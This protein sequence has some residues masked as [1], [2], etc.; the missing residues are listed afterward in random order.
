M[1]QKNIQYTVNCH[2]AD[3]HIFT[4][5]LQVDMVTG[6][7]LDFKMAAWTPGS[8]LIREY[9]RN[10]IEFSAKSGRKSLSYQKINKNTWRVDLDDAP[11]V[12]VQYTVYAYE[13]TVRTSFLNADQA[14][15]NGASVFLFPSERTNEAMSVKMET[16][17]SWETIKTGLTQEKGKINTFFAD[18]LDQL[19]DSPIMAGNPTVLPFEASG[20]PHE[21]VIFGTGNYDLN[22]IISDTQKILHSAHGIFG[23]VPY[24]NYTFFLHTMD[25][26]YGG[27]EHH[28]NCHMIFDP[29]KFSDPK[30]YIKFIGLVSH[31]FFHTYNVKRIRPKGLGPFDY[32][33]EFYTNQHWITEGITSYFDNHILLR[34]GV[35][36][37]EQYLELIA[38]DLL[39][40]DNTPGRLFQSVYESSFDQWIKL[41]RADEN[42][43]NSGISY[44]LKGSLVALCLDLALRKATSGKASLD[45]VYLK[46]WKNYLKTG[47][48]FKPEYFLNLCEKTAG[49][50]LKS[51]WQML[52]TTDE[53]NFNPVLEAF[54]LNIHKSY[55][56][57][58]DKT[59][60]W[61]GIE[62]DKSN[63]IIKKIL[64]NSPAWSEGLNVH[65]EILAVNGARITLTNCDAII[66]GLST[67]KKT[68]MLIS[69]RGEIKTI[70]V[71]PQSKPPNKL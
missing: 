46:L 25:A 19:F 53:I 38:M 56:K 52:S 16:P 43:V 41:Y 60:S 37:A 4:V 34:S 12:T 36:T 49:T 33:Q 17:H 30:E 23:S 44:Y 13:L 24:D 5:K 35:I 2:Q 28:N 42:S 22:K 10:I 50:E 65:D 20:I 29:W 18:N 1:T 26:S 58:E 27:L 59:I 15:I 39:R 32:D 8:Y 6:K 45:T 64:L 69:R 71:K 48:G 68:S 70:S 11:Q 31:E 40:L 66:G 3:T 57:P 54:G 61:L 62:Y 67:R 21:Y 51:I 7:Y 47:N 55:E 63:F 9:C 14:V